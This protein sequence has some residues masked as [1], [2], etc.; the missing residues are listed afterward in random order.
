MLDDDFEL[1]TIDSELYNEIRTAEVA[2]EGAALRAHAWA[3]VTHRVAL[4]LLGASL[5][6]SL[7]MHWLPALRPWSGEA[8]WVLLLGFAAYLAVVAIVYWMRPTPAAP[9]LRRLREIRHD[10]A[11]LLVQQKRLPGGRQN[12]VLIGILS[13]AIRH[14][15]EQVIPALEQLVERRANLGRV[16]RRYERGQAQA[17]GPELLERLQM[18]HA[19]LMAAIEEC[20]Q[21]AANAYAML[22]ALLQEGDDENVAARARAW[23][24]DLT[25]MY[26]A[27][28]EV[29][30]GTEE[31]AHAE[32]RPFE[33]PSRPAPDAAGSPVG[34]QDQCVD[35]LTPAVEDALRRMRDPGKLVG[36]RLLGYL[37]WTIAAELRERRN[38][39]GGVA[40]PL[41]QAGALQRVLIS[42]VDRLRPA[43]ADH[44]RGD[45]ATRCYDLIRGQYVEG[46]PITQ[47]KWQHSLS[48]STYHRSRR[49][50][51]RI[52]ARELCEQEALYGR[53]E[54]HAATG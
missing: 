32:D 11:A 44:G 50:A 27:L 14:L 26:D 49:Q 42:A 21:Q 7:A 4:A 16:L 40:T 39:H 31:P 51:I 30:R 34:R 53:D 5:L 35:V 18:L 20:V 36:C 33:A 9:E 52:L 12:A 6:L 46:R 22:V 19:R 24:E 41:E 1:W 10:I 29:L 8:R 38:G 28:T 47:L 13:D 2:A 25:R 17:P 37:P 3:A 48:E 23:A 15:D 45:G 43:D 54:P